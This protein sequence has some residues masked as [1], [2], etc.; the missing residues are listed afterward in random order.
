MKLV[1]IQKRK[2]FIFIQQ[3]GHKI[4]MENFILYGLCKEAMILD[5]MKFRVG[6]TAS[7]K[8]GNSVLR[9]RAKRRMKALAVKILSPLANNNIEYL[10]IA[11]SEILISVWSKLE[12][13]MNESI[14]SLHKNL[15]NIEVK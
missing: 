14:I 12:L 7:K 8:I 13:E 5:S 9:N 3:N 1:T 11:R 2:D 15:K 10:M 6:F 4:L